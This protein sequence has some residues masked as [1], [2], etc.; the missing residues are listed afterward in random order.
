MPRLVGAQKDAWEYAHETILHEEIH[1]VGALKPGFY[2]DAGA[3]VEEVATEISARKISRELGGLNYGPRGGADGKPRS[4]VAYQELI[5]DVYDAM[6]EAAFD[7]S[8][9][10]LEGGKRL[11]KASTLTALD[12]WIEH[13]AL[14]FKRRAAGSISTL[15][16]FV[17]AFTDSLIQTAPVE[18]SRR[19]QQ[20]LWGK[21]RR[22]RRTKAQAPASRSER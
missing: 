14:H 2:R 7:G 11:A 5:D 6:G 17:D 13:A 15:D 9:F 20:T 22:M 12:S 10:R 4:F 8:S 21:V 16:E 1:G 19:A 18:L 3:V